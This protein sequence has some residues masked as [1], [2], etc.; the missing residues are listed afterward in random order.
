MM[1]L[2]SRHFP[3]VVFH[4]QV[5]PDYLESIGLQGY[6]HVFGSPDGCSIGWTYEDGV[7]EVCD[8]TFKI[9]REWKIIDWCDGGV[10]HYDQVIKV[11]DEEGPTFDCPANITVSTDPFT[12][13][14]TVDLPDFIATDNCSRIKA[15]TA[16]VT[17][18]DPQTGQ[19]LNMYNVGGSMS[20]FPGN[21]LWEPD[22]MVNVGST[23]CLPIGT[24]LVSYTLEDDCGNTS[25]CTFRVIVRDYTPPVAACDEYTVVGI[26]V[27]DPFDC[28]GP[29]GFL[30]VPP[31]LDACNFAGVTWVKA[32]TFDDGSYDNCGDVR[33]SI[34]RMA[35]YSDCITGLNPIRGFPDCAS[36]FPTF[37][38]EFERAITEGDS[39]K[40]YCCEVGTEQTVILTVYQ[41]DANGNIVVGPSG[42]PVRNECMI[43]V[44]VQDKIKPVCQSPANVTVSC[45]NF[46]PSLWAYGKAAVY[47]NCC[48]DTAQ[49]YQ[50]QC[51]LSH[52][53]NYNFFDTLCSKGTITRTFRAF[54]CHG[55]S[56]QCTQRIFVNYEQDYWLKFPNDVIVTVC[57]GTGN[58]GEPE[59]NGEDCELLGVSFEDEIFT[60]VP[61]ACY[62]IERTWTVINWCTYSPNQPC[63]EVPNPNPNATSNNPANLVGPTISPLGTPQPWQPTNVRVNPTDPQTLNYSVFYHGGTYTNYATNQQVTVPSIANNNCFKYKQIIKII[64]GQKPVVQ[65][66][67]SP[68]EICDLTANDPQFWNESYWYDSQ[69]GSHDLCEA[70]TDLCITAT[71]LCSGSNVNIRY[72]LFLDLNGDGV[73]ETVV[74]SSNPP[75]YNNVQFGNAQNPNFTGGTPSAFD[76]RPVPSNQKYGFTIQN[77]VSGNDKTACVRWNTIQQPNNYV[78]PQLPYGTHKIKWVITDGCGNEEICEYTFVVKDCKKPT[79]VC[80]NGLSVNIMPTQMIALWDTDF[81]QYTEDNCTPSNLLKTAIR[82]SGTGTGFPL[83]PDGTPQKSVTFDC[84]E[85]GTQFVELWSIDLAGNADYCETY[86]I[87]QDNMGICGTNLAT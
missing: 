82:K 21:N 31:A 69:T 20:S 73:M 61:D 83:N 12:C 84:S 3:A 41:L 35:P 67:A 4:S 40:F 62:K 70:P 66:P 58:Y 5:T 50:G 42:E 2:T 46:D 43:T 33:F 1:T 85:L 17:V 24:H 47:D 9:V 7:I 29:A 49:V 72:I 19:V 6:P 65:C 32:T 59:F 60:V 80:I 79:V 15:V 13:C 39:I 52:T 37:P 55:Q 75:G 16:M 71:D 78:V 25:T 87:V 14:S 28:Y 48:L 38:S 23:P 63:V 77:T 36:P 8:G 26:G 68:V 34:R 44:S 57:D 18:T 74:S 27:D 11:L 86:V 64:D 53:A 81:L 54:D 45:E 76:E 56:S 30:D 51:G 22:T 10:N